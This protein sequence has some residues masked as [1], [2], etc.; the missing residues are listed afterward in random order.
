[1]AAGSDRRILVSLCTLLGGEG[2]PEQIEGHD[3]TLVLAGGAL[4]FG[5]LL[6]GLNLT[7]LF[8]A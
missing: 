4:Y 1:M 6:V 8:G 2:A 3:T 7:D 5:L